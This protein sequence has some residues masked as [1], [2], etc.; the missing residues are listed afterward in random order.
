M[1]SS[2]VKKILLVSGRGR[3]EDVWHD[4]AATSH[5]VATVLSEAG[6]EVVV[7]GSF[8]DA[9]DD[10]QTAGF[11]L[12]VVNTSPG[13]TDAEHDGDDA[14]WAP[15]H[16]SVRAWAD[17]GRPVLGLHQS[18]SS[19]ADSEH[20]ERILGGRWVEGMSMHPPIGPATF[21]VSDPDHPVVSPLVSRVSGAVTA[22]DERYS[23]LR[24][25]PE[26]QVL[27]TQRHDGVVHPVVWVHEAGGVRVVYD[28]LGHDVRSY[29]SATRRTLL[30]SEV[31]WLLGEAPLPR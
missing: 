26:V 13:R 8:R 30:R 6:H 25:S 7:R 5:R 3:Y 4:M 2:D 20:W 11:D 23:Y 16:E 9:L 29:D 31:A 18:A 17:A 27:L 10:L 24:V 15:F 1:T 28:S 19:F 14:S 22:F 12:L 21:T